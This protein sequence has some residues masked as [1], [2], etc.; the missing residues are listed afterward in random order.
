MSG[1]VTIGDGAA[2]APGVILQAN[3]GSRIIIAAGACIGMGVVL[4]AHEGTLEIGAGATLGAVVLVIGK[5][6]IG[7]NACIGSATTVWNSNVEPGKVVAPGSLI[8]DTSRQV[9]AAEEEPQ[10]EG[11]NP[12]P[13]R[14]LEDLPDPNPQ[15]PDPSPADPP[16]PSAAPA[17]ENIGLPIYGQVHLSQLLVTLFPHHQS[18][19]PTTQNDKMD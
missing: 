19:K 5:G 14:D 12:I 4:H 16:T 2:I 6:K 8:G 10:I 15:S 18:F 11:K 13:D 7:A 3:P 9:A 1:D 17:I